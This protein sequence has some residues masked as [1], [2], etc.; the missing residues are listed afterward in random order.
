MCGLTGYWT[1]GGDGRGRGEMT[2]LVLRMAGALAHRG[3]D[4]DGAWVDED[5]GLALGH[6][7]L[8]IVDL[9]PAGQQ[10]MVSADGRLALAYNGE[11]YNAA[12]LRPE[13]EAAGIVFRGHSD[14]EVLLEGF[15]RWGVVPTLR[16]AIGMFAFAL[17]DRKERRLTLGRDRLGIKPLY[18]ADHGGTL[19][20]ASQPKGMMPHPSWRGEVDREG[21]AAMLRLS[22]L[23]APR[24]IFKGVSQ[25]APGTVVR[26]EA[27][28]RRSEEVFWSLEE[29]A[30]RG[31]AQAR[32]QPARP[33]SASLA[34]EHLESLLLDAVRRRLIADVPVGAF[35]SGGVDSSTVV[36]LMRKVAS[37]PVKT[38]SIGFAEEGWD[39]SV[40]AAAVARHLGTDHRELVVSPDEVPA[41]VGDLPRWYDEPFADASQIPTLL[42]SK[43]ARSEV[44]VSLSGDGGDEL[45][46]GYNR[47]VQGQRLWDL[48][49]RIPTVG[50]DLGA[51]LIEAP[52]PGFWQ[53]A[54]GLLPAGRRPPQA[55]DKPA[56]IARLLRARSPE[57]LYRTLVGAMPSA[58]VPLAGVSL[59]AEERW[60][61][62][63]AEGVDSFVDRMR[64]LDAKGYLPDDILTKV[65]RASMAYGLEAR[66]PLL[67]HRVV[68]FAWSLPP[69]MLIR[70]GQGKWLLRR[71]LH[72]HVPRALIERPKMGF[73]VPLAAW[74]R[75][76]LRGWA[77]DL[78]D[79]Q[80]MAVQGLIDPA[81]VRRWWLDH[82]AGRRD[83]HDR[84]WPVLSALS[85]HHHWKSAGAFTAA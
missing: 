49:Q 30:A 67:D 6:R 77:E 11:I 63:S 38:F 42:V 80:T 7:R 52:S 37:G 81:P 85:W 43:L 27:D 84:L 58:E 82:L 31:V 17:W 15:A 44:T 19:L 14:T 71:V 65:D 51:A 48:A 26:F 1:R 73:G 13:L 83:T 76:P 3:P 78:L 47:H 29:V 50:R 64:L 61:A 74:L 25:L 39:E 32:S 72:R 23:P 45:F 53:R 8:S 4:G 20:F 28:G 57:A 34:V 54:V 41:I 56:K 75:G 21:L 22:C 79:P 5:A 18:V 40:H 10:P 46:A 16:R 35:L 55:A 33:E 66:V 24:S 60:Y 68:E 69:E 12:E 36:A 70:E 59:A 9:S 62:A 2:A